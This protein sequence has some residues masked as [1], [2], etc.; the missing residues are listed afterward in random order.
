[1]ADLPPGRRRLRLPV[2]IRAE[3]AL[4][5][6]ALVRLALVTSEVKP[7]YYILS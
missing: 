7:I 1:M 4:P 5:A 2:T 3:S 6:G